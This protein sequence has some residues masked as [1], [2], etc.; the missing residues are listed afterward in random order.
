MVRAEVV[1]EF[2][3]ARDRVLMAASVEMFTCR[4]RSS[5]ETCIIH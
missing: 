3:L 1:T 5:C 2:M 4:S